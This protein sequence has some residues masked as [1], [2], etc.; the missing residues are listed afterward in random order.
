ME[1]L[2]WLFA[3]ILFGVLPAIVAVR[4]PSPFWQIAAGVMFVAG[5]VFVV[6]GT[7]MARKRQGRP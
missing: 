3:F 5:V 1:F 7:K 4:A 2:K 6:I